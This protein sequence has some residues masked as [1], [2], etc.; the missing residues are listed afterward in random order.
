[1]FTAT[2]SDNTTAQRSAI[3]TATGKQVWPRAASRP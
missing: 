3:G 2:F 1:V